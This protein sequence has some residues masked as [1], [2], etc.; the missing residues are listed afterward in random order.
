M[1]K[2]KAEKYMWSLKKPMYIDK[3]DKRYKSYVRQ[4]KKV[5]FSDTETW[6]LDSV[7]SEFILPRLKRFKETCNGFPGGRGLTMNKWYKML[8][9]MIFAFEWNVGCNADSNFNLSEKE[10]KA[11]WKKYK[12]GMSL[13]SEYFRDL[14]W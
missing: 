9:K 14:W 11:N 1:K 6:N 10:E 3:T 4:L 7:I 8:D 2:E 13:F 12:E 5:G